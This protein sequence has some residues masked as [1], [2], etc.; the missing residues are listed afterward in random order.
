MLF[1]SPQN[2]SDFHFYLFSLG[3]IDL[4]RTQPRQEGVSGYSLLLVKL[5][6]WCRGGRRVQK[7]HK[8]RAYYIYSPVLKFPRFSYFFNLLLRIG[9][10]F[11]ILSPEAG[12]SVEC[13]KARKCKSKILVKLFKGDVWN[14]LNYVKLRYHVNEIH[15][16]QLLLPTNCPKFFFLRNTN[17]KSVSD[18]MES[19]VCGRYWV[20]FAT[21]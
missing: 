1:Q 10:I 6:Y 9:Q 13:L 19:T 4:V 17:E 5:Y 18:T 3:A 15:R 7:S 20:F 11:S 8:L 14:C 12:A 2:F 16:N 21:L